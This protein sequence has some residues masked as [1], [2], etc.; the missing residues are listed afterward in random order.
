MHAVKRKLMQLYP[1]STY[2]YFSCGR[3]SI[4]SMRFEDTM[5]LSGDSI[6]LP[7]GGG[8][9]RTLDIEGKASSIGYGR[10]QEPN[11]A[12]DQLFHL[13]TG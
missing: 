7:S 3:I 4:I 11:E 10:Y 6:F 1:Y 8:S 9:R 12:C 2:M 5:I 13:Y